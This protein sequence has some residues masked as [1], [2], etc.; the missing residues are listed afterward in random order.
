MPSRSLRTSFRNHLREQALSAA[1]TLTIEKGWERVRMGEVADLVGV[2]RPTLYKEFADKKGLGDALLVQEAERFLAGIDRI[3]EENAGDVGGGITAAVRYTIAEAE[4]SPLLRAVL[5]AN[6][7]V[8]PEAT[9]TGILPLLPTS[10]SLL[11]L[12]SEALVTWFLEHFPALDATDV[13]DVVDAMVRLTV[14]GLVLP[15][16]DA[17][18]TADRISRVAIRYLHLDAL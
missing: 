15:A 4:T 9:G 8:E 1:R 13:A 3:L 2:S 16:A 10:A 14:S 11:Q 17:S 12:A 5:T 7:G 6:H 18:S